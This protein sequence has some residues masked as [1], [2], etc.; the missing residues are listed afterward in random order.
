MSRTVTAAAL[1]PGDVIRLRAD[2]LLV[3]STTHKC[4]GAGGRR[5]VIRARSARDAGGIVERS[6]LDSFTFTVDDEKKDAI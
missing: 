1:T 4:V 5:T 2:S 3:L 6:Y